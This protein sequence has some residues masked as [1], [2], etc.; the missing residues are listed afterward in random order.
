MSHWTL[1][2]GDLDSWEL[3]SCQLL[4]GQ[5]GAAPFLFLPHFHLDTLF[6][7]LR[8]ESAP[9]SVPLDS[10]LPVISGFC[11]SPV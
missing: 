1:F 7:S 5:L 2:T 10:H 8:Y 6:H 9:G 3:P 4:A 11:V